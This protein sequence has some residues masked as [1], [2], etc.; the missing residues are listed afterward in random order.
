MNKGKLRFFHLGLFGILAASV[1]LAQTPKRIN[2]AIE[3]LSQGQP[4]YYTGSHEGM[5]ANYEAGVK[6]A[7]TWADYINFD[8][9]HAPFNVSALAEFMRGLSSAGPIKSGHRMPAVIV[10]L[11]TDATDEATMR[12]NAWMVKH[13]LATGT[14]RILLCH[15]QS[16]AA[17]K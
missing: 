11:P 14:H 9:E 17:V 4:I 12:A 13:V 10:T 15:A 1:A 7:Q 8:M 3:L 6:M 5:S 2:K 16:P